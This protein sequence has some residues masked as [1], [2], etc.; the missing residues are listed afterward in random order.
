M[1][2]IDP[3]YNIVRVSDTWYF[4]SLCTLELYCFLSCHYFS[5]EHNM[6]INPYL[7]TF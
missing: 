3:T 4:L 2:L 7:K 5:L 6:C 1:S